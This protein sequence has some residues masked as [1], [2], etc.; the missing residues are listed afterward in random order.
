MSLID[1]RFRLFGLLLLTLLTTGQVNAQPAANEIPASRLHRLPPGFFEPTLRVPFIPPTGAEIAN[2]AEFCRADAMIISW[3]SWHA[4]EL[5]EMTRVAAEDDRVICIYSGVGEYTDAF[6]RMTNSGVNMANVHFLETAP[7]TV[8]IRDYGPFCAY[9]DGQLAITDFRYGTGG[10]WD[11]I[12][13]AIA[14]DAG[15]PSYRTNLTHTGGNHLTDGNGM[16]FFTTNL[17]LGNSSWSQAQIEEEMKAYL[18]L[19]S[20]V[21]FGTMEGDATGHCDMFVKLLNDT[22]FVVGEYENPAH[23]MGDD[24]AFLDDL[25]TM[26]DSLENLDGRDFEVRRIPMNPINSSFA[27]NRS[28]TNSLILNDKVLVP[29]YDTGMDREALDIY[30][31]CMPQHEIIG[32]NCEELIPYLGAIH[33]VSNTLHDA[34]PLTIL[35]EPLLVAEGGDAPVLDCRLNP[36][37]TD[38]E[39]LLHYQS[40]NGD[41][42]TVTAEFGGGVW[43]AQLPTLDSDFSYW[44]TARVFTE[45]HT[46]ETSLPEGAPSQVFMV[47]VETTTGTGPLPTSAPTLTA[48]PNPCNPRTLLAFTLAKDA[49]V[50]LEI[51][52]LSGRRQ[53]VLVMGQ[54]LE[55]GGHEFAWNGQDDGGRALPSG[56]YL[57]RL[58]AGDTSS[59]KRVTLVR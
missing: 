25:A 14:D 9:D 27:Y 24:A 3:T 46:M 55:R 31:E 52:D 11:A 39:V 42:A 56:V 54:S 51:Y 48:W 15:L 19:E 59:T 28:Y 30:A 26:L 16:G 34:N 17:T 22:L 8:W 7:A 32:I 38:R 21:I 58:R 4:A 10:D 43:R 57:A 50:A 33:C 20:L 23:A 13:I 53:R 45:A 12:P 47:E 29:I 49:K 41:E 5:L 6:Q 35:H 37:F 18:G 44:Y 36:R 40:E 2:P 1:M